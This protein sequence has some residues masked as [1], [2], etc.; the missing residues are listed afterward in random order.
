MVIVTRR[1]FADRLMRFAGRNLGELLFFFDRLSYSPIGFPKSKFLCQIASAF[2]DESKRRSSMP[3]FYSDRFFRHR[4]FLRLS[5]RL[6]EAVFADR[7]G[8]ILNREPASAGAL[9]RI[10]HD[11][12]IAPAI[13]LQHLRKVS[14]A[15][16]DRGF[17]VEVD[18][19]KLHASITVKSSAASSAF[20]PLG[21]PI[22]S[23][24][25]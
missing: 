14:R 22:E 15:V 17:P 7:R 13:Q 3:I 1:A 16:D 12:L 4:R 11:R 23:Q 9:L 20:N 6:D 19:P 10:D 18:R 2:I 24:P 25:A 8:W 5:V 21:R